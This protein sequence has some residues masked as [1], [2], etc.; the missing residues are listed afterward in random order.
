MK[1]VHSDPGL[2]HFGVKKIVDRLRRWA[3]WPPMTLSV[4]KYCESCERCQAR[5]QPAKTPR[6]PLKFI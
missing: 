6:A 5:K 1:M 2:G 4:S 3:Y